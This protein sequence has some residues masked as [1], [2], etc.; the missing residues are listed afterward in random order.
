MGQGKENPPKRGFS[1]AHGQMV[2]G[3]GKQ[4]VSKWESENIII[5]LFHICMFIYAQ[6]RMYIYINGN[7][8]IS[9][10]LMI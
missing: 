4:R 5:L 6:I 1:G 7:K 8:H 2:F 3:R 10:A 9:D